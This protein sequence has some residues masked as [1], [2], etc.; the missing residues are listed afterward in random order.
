MSIQL[1]KRACLAFIFLVLITSGYA[2]G[3]TLSD[4]SAGDSLTLKG[5]IERVI[6]THPTIK[7][8]E[9]AIN[10]ADAKIGLAK[11][12][13]LPV[14]SLD[15][16]IANI[17]PVTKLTIPDMGTFQLYPDNN[18][19]AAIN[20]RQVIFDFGRTRQGIAMANEGKNMGEQSLEQIKQKM[21]LLAV[22]NYYS[23]LYLQAALKIKGEEIS[24]LNEHLQQVEKMKATGSATEYQV[25]STKVKISFVEGQKVDIKAALEAQQAFLNALTGNEMT[26]RPVVKTDLSAELPGVDFDSLLTFAYKNRDEMLINNERQAIAGLRYEMIKILN[27]PILSFQASG[28]AKNGYIP[29]LNKITPNY[30]VGLGFSMPVFDGNRKKYNLAQARSAINAIGFE[31]ESTKRTIYSEI[32][33]AEAYMYAAREKIGQFDLQLQQAFKAYSLAETS[34]K[35][36]VITNLDLLDANTA[37]S[38]SKLMLLKARIDYSASIYRLKAA[39]GE[40]LYN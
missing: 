24:A 26:A 35:S 17:G 14:A 23:M 33:Q 19:S 38:E 34:F 28:G 32:S 12:G 11:T 7:D 30:V 10:E 25:L 15:A 36:G 4:T 37:V 21:S 8:A 5:I 3:Q 29:N 1:N 27:R 40:R 9:E 22:N 18:Y 16:G 6:A 20:F 31:S 2:S 39:L 13:Y